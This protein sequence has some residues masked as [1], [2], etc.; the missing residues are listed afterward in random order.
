MEWILFTIG[1]LLGATIDLQCNGKLNLGTERRAGLISIVLER[2]IAT[3]FNRSNALRSL[4]T[5][6]SMEA[7]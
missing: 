4:S 3:L 1:L 6:D 7:L 5:N 2:D